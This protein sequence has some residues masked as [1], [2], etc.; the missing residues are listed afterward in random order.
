MAFYAALVLLVAVAGKFGGSAVAARLM[1]T[2]WREA[3]AIGILM[4]TRGLIELVVLN[5]GLEIGVLTRPMFR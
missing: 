4:N 5:I 1:G 2:P 3:T